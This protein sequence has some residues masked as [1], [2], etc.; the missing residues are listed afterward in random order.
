M[1]ANILLI[2]VPTL[3]IFLLINY[4]FACST[5]IQNPNKTQVLQY[6]NQAKIDNVSGI[7]S[8]AALPLSP[9]V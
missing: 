9:R 2:L 4:F 7:C 1:K 3:I 6:F 8:L 5:F